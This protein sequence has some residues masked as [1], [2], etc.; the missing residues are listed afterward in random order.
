MGTGMGFL[1]CGN[2]V[3]YKNEQSGKGESV[4]YAEQ[5]DRD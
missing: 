2:A 5:F 1:A 4:R 3:L